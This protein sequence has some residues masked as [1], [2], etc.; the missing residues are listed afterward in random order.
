MRHV[1]AALFLMIT[2]V[3]TSVYARESLVIGATI[4]NPPF[5][6]LSDNRDHFIGFEV[7]IMNVICNKLNLSCTY[8]P[9]LASEILAGLAN[10]TIDVAITAVIIPS[11]QQQNLIFSL[12]Y[13]PSNAQFMTLKTSSINKVAD[14]PTK[15]IG[16][17]RGTLDSGLMFANFVRRMFKNKITVK[18]YL[19]MPELINGLSQGEVDAIFANTYSLYYWNNLSQN[20]YKLLDKPIEVGN[21]YGFITTS[22][23]FS[24]TQKANLILEGMMT[25]GS[26]ITLY[27]KYFEKFD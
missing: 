23:N 25:D 3:H 12:P 13:L 14:L 22:K 26:Y 24:F 19:S 20:T 11:I 10:G 8:K 15:R 17:R 27:N 7:D 18:T 2:S 1:L 6:S 9:I 5:V 16:V 21:G 4:G